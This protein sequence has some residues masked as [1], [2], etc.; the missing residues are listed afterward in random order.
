MLNAAS[1]TAQTS[2]PS[3][4]EVTLCVLLVLGQRRPHTLRAL[5]RPHAVVQSSARRS[6][7]QVLLVALEQ[8]GQDGVHVEGHGKEPERTRFARTRLGPTAAVLLYEVCKVSRLEQHELALFS[9]EY[10]L[11][12]FRLVE[13]TRDEDEQ[14]NYALIRVLVRVA[15]ARTNS[16]RRSPSTSNTWSRRSAAPARPRSALQ[17]TSDLP[18]RP[19]AM[20]SFAR[21]GSI[22]AR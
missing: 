6:V 21:C 19:T 17:R 2:D 20:S 10:I 3:L 9:P 14:F 5:R 7:L 22:P 16:P 12:L 11:L 15:G 13:S 18:A 4:L 8:Y 1:L